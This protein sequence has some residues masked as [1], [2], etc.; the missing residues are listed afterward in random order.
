M[1][2][3]KAA[4][5]NLKTWERQVYAE[6]VDA[7]SVLQQRIIITLRDVAIPSCKKAGRTKD[8]KWAQHNYDVLT[9]KKKS[10]IKHKN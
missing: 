10:R 4:S 8:L 2:A 9:G 1:N 7:L 5:F 6:N 3:I